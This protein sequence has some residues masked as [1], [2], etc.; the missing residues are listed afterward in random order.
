MCI[1]DS[2]KGA[3]RN[4][5]GDTSHTSINDIVEN[6]DN[7]DNGTHENTAVNKLPVFECQKVRPSSENNVEL[8]AVNDLTDLVKVTEKDLYNEHS[9]SKELSNSSL[10][11]NKSLYSQESKQNSVVI[12]K[13]PDNE[14]EESDVAESDNSSSVNLSCDLHEQMCIRDS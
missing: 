3:N 9:L 2:N 13:E 1:R 6:V 8:S 11:T 7:Y 14:H 4:L 10:D 12:D 5:V